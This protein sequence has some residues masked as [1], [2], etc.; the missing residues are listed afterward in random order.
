MSEFTITE[1]DI[2]RYVRRIST[3]DIGVVRADRGNGW[4]HPGFVYEWRSYASDLEYVEVSSSSRVAELEEICHQATEDCATV[5]S[6][7]LDLHKLVTGGSIAVD[8]CAAIKH[9]INELIEANNREVERRRATEERYE[10]Q[11]AETRK[12]RQA[13]HADRRRGLA[14]RRIANDLIDA[15]DDIDGD[16]ATLTERVA[17]LVERARSDT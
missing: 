10:R 4:L 1:A 15:W 5:L 14:A 12:W 8:L 2:G 6:E 16:A 9:R 7:L 17:A 3:G 13:W 11:S